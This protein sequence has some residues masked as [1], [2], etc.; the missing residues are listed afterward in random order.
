[1]ILLCIGGDT[2]ITLEF[3]NGCKPVCDQ[4]FLS[5]SLQ[6]KMKMV[7]V[8]QCE[9]LDGAYFVSFC[10]PGSKE[11]HMF[12]QVQFPFPSNAWGRGGGVYFQASTA[13]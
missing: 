12:F 10:F 6:W 3:R 7:E 5:F 11:V 1:M 13:I 2:N 4:N 9:F 8:E